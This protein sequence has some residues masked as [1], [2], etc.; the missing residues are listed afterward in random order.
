MRF[1]LALCTAYAL[2]LDAN[3]CRRCKNCNVDDKSIKVDTADPVKLEPEC[4]PK[5]PKFDFRVWKKKFLASKFAKFK[6]M[7]DTY[8]G[9]EAARLMEKCGGNDY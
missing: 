3:R 6:E 1:L 7:R 2:Q 9:T 4:D 5:S 8:K